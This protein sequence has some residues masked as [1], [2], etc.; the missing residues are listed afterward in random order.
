MIYFPEIFNRTPEILAA[1]SKRHGG[2]SVHP[3]YS[4]NLGLS[5]GDEVVHVLN[6]R[7]KFFSGLGIEEKNVATSGQIHGKEILV[8][9]KAGRFSG[10]DAIITNKKNLFVA[11][12]IADCCPVLIYDRKNQA[13]A[14]IHAGWRGTVSKIVSETL[15]SMKE[16]FGTEAQNIMAYIGTC[17]SE[18]SF[19]VGEEVATQFDPEFISDTANSEKYYINLKAANLKQLLDFGVDKEEIEISPYCTILN[20]DEYFSYRKEGKESGRMLAIIGTKS[21]E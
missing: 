16:N 3:Y 7:N 9:D 21:T 11:V 20:N 2:D 6:N 13:V 10:Y 15:T 19:E 1:Q 14:A 8:T 4:L 17:I 18:K 12:S 5:T